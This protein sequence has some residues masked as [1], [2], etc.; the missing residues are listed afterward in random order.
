MVPVMVLPLSSP[1]KVET[2][3]QL[4]PGSMY[5][6]SIEPDTLS[7][8]L[9]EA[10]TDNPLVDGAGAAFLPLA[11]AAISIAQ[12]S[13]PTILPPVGVSWSCPV[14]DSS[15]PLSTSTKLPLFEV[16]SLVYV[17]TQRPAS[18]AGAAIDGP[19]GAGA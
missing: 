6:P 5:E 19:A 12:P 15:E 3:L 14:A 18:A 10:V 17:P 2:T 8:P 16:T 9:F 1:S 4:Q 11:G 13:G 7:S